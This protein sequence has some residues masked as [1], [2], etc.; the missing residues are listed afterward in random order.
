MGVQDWIQK[1]VWVCRCVCM[2]VCVL[3]R[4]TDFRTVPGE[5]TLQQASRPVSQMSSCVHF[6][7]LPRSP[8]HG[9]GHMHRA[10]RI[11]EG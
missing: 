1:E 6:H 8:I 2:C 4:T 9:L 5:N 7:L 10:M 3:G 11:R